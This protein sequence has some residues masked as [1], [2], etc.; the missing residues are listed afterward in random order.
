MI[1]TPGLP[2]SMDETRVTS[3]ASVLIVAAEESSCKYALKVMLELKSK[4]PQIK[5][6]G[7]GNLE[8]QNH[9]F[10][11][12]ARAEDLAV[13]GLI[14]VLKNQKQIRAAYNAILAKVR[15]NPPKV[16]LLLDYGGFNLRLAAD[17]KKYNIKVVYY[18][19]PKVWVWKQNRVF[20]I[21]K[22]VDD[23]LV[24]HPFE[25]DFYKKFNVDAKYVGH[26]LLE[27]FEAYQKSHF[28]VAAFKN[29]LGLDGS[30][31]V[32]LMPGSRNSEIDRLLNPMLQTAEKLLQSKP[33]L[34]ISLLVAPGFEIEDFKK[35]FTK[36]Y[37]FPIHFI[38]EDSWRMIDVCD[39]MITASG[40]ATVQVGLLK[41]PQIVVYK[42]NAFTGFLAKIVV[43]GI[44]NFGL[45]NIILGRPITEEF[46]QKTATAE[47]MAPAMLRLMNNEGDRQTKMLQ[48]YEYLENELKGAGAAK[49]V[50]E[51]VGQYL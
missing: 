7:V 6:W 23:V 26:P 11:R 48:D 19:P 21:K 35:R 50:S 34:N 14:E 39:F 24:V 41:K 31:N 46:F 13:I 22:F 43:T 45:I 10:G 15:Q 17:L 32:G 16:A 37:D 25:V 2:A 36:P 42:L 33:N 28:P 51:V 12:Q 49:L 9:G 5:F 4:N 29:K 44:K 18:I 1:S 40:T 38:K 3:E 47:Y 20:K 27:E 30:L 8:M